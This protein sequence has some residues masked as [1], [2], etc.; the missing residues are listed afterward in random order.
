MTRDR[1]SLVRKDARKIPSA[2]CPEDCGLALQDIRIQVRPGSTLR[3]ADV[4]MSV[5]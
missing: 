3:R 5:R 1:G 2:S 4:D